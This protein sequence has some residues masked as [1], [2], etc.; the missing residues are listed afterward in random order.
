MTRRFLTPPRQPPAFIRASRRG[1]IGALGLIVLP[2]WTVAA[3][4]VVTIT[5]INPGPKPFISVVSLH[6]AD[7]NLLSYVS[8]T[9]EPKEGSYTNPVNARYSGAYLLGRGYLNGQTGGI[10][11]PVFGLYAGATNR[12]KL[13]TGFVDGTLQVDELSITTAKYNGGIYNH[14]AVVQARAMHTGLSYDF[15]ILK[16]YAD[17]DSP[18]VIDTD[19][20]LRWVG[21]ANTPSMEAI[22]YHNS[23]FIIGGTQLL[24]MEWDGTVS[25]V[26]DLASVG[27]TSVHHNIDFGKAGFF[28]DIDTAEY[29]ESSI[30]ELNE[31]GALLQTWNLAGIITAAMIAGGDD[32]TQ[33][34]PAAGS[35][36]D[37][38]HLNSAAYRP[39][40]DSVVVSSRENFVI[41]LD[42]SSGAIKWI[43]GDPTKQWYQ[44]PSLRRYA[45]KVPPGGHYPLGQHALSFPNDKLLLFDDGLA[46]E[47]HTPPGRNRTYSAPRKYTINETA[48]TATEIWNYV[49]DPRIYSPIESSV[50][51]DLPGNY[52]VDYA[53]G[54]PYLF[55]EIIGLDPAGA[56][57]FDYKF[58]EIME[59]DTAWIAV[60]VHLEDVVFD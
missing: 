24:R 21:T 37:W 52:L 11:V 54:G 32:P 28:V 15:I 41:A 4:P 38:F 19:G 33:F 23:F 17:G 5:G 44:F 26:V 45:L 10:T 49:S 42:Y 39:S 18:K 35:S 16:S 8:F 60:P 48:G 36:D 6:L 43:L 30:M 25:T 31:A 55:A 22:L 29:L 34:V 14:P 20:E 13:T 47:H 7:T 12:V 40:D 2:L 56:K 58:T 9:I 51:E 50:Y 1:L 27:V 57:A 59:A 46:S 3:R 53:V